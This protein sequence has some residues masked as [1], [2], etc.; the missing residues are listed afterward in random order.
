MASRTTQ[1]VVSFSSAFRLPGFDGQQPA[2]SY[3]VDSD[4]ESIEGSSTCLGSACERRRTRWRRSVLRIS[5]PQS[6]RTKRMT[7]TKDQKS[8]D[9]CK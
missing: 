8:R 1:T 7:K 2:G 5:M 9:N 6:N 4:E 3:R